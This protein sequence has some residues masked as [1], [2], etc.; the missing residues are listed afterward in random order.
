MLSDF[1]N[2]S[3]TDLQIIVARATFVDVHVSPKIVALSHFS[4][5]CLQSH[6]FSIAQTSLALKLDA[7]SIPL[8]GRPIDNGQGACGPWPKP[9]ENGPHFPAMDPTGD[10][11]PRLPDPQAPP[12]TDLASYANFVATGLF[13]G[14]YKELYFLGLVGC[15]IDRFIQW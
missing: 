11:V 3:S 1:H 14:N 7:M 10:N 9:K 2:A 5:H 15:K 12:P 13:P 4:I 6:T 8:L